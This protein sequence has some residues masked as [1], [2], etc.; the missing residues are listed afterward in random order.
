MEK[1]EVV[2]TCPRRI[3]GR[4]E[5]HVKKLL[6]NIEPESVTLQLPEHVNMGKIIGKGGRMAKQLEA[7]VQEL[8]SSE[9]CGAGHLHVGRGQV[10]KINSQSREIVVTLEG[11]SRALMSVIVGRFS[12]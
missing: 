8:L 4:V 9:R 2:I 12:L 6:R 5:L 7:N 11:A 3:Y 1:N 10:I